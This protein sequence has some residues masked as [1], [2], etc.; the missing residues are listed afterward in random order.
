MTRQTNFAQWR[1]EASGLIRDMRVIG[2]SDG[3]IY[4]ELVKRY[5]D[6]EPV[7]I[8]KVVVERPETAKRS[9]RGHG[10]L[11]SVHINIRITASD[12]AALLVAA[13]RAGNPGN[14]SAGLRGAAR[15]VKPTPAELEQLKVQS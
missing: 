5:P 8:K 11:Q 4:T 3:D 9:K 15:L 13:E 6:E 1:K 14:I 2:M 12:L 10:R 7:R